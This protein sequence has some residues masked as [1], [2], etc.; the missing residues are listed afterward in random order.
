VDEGVS[1]AEDT[2]IGAMVGL[3]WPRGPFA[4][5]NRIGIGQAV[6]AAADV[7]RRHDLPLPSLLAGRAEPFALQAVSL[8]V[9]DGLAR[10]TMNRPNAMN[11]LDPET[12]ASLARAFDAAAADPAATAI[13]LEG[14]GKAFVAG[15]DIKFFIRGIDD[16]DIPRIVDFTRV[17]QELFLRIDRCPKPV[18]ARLNGLALGGGAELALA[19][20][21]IVAEP[22]ASIGFPETGIGIYPGLGGTQRLVGRT[23][24]AVARSLVL[25]GDVLP[26]A[27][28]AD[29]GLVDRVAPSGASMDAVR[30]LLADGA[31]EAGEGAGG[32]A[33]PGAAKAA[34][35]ALYTDGN[36]AA[37]LDGTFQPTD[38]AAGKAYKK[39]RAKAPVALKMADELMRKAPSTPI[40]EGVELELGGLPRI[41]STKDARAGL[42]SVI[43]RTRPTY[44]GR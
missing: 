2:D 3:R 8:I 40:A 21:A 15:A 10:I 18:V 20:D 5:A 13:V 25:T 4:L 14:R 11:A 44:E 28:A 22:G 7:A 36:V 12:V 38:D 39:L 31:V 1:S 17:G 30:Q 42:G 34:V 32:L 16:G 33:R 27:R 9:E 24:L 19:C 6:E 26:A 41:F 37:M 43:D 29:L 23:G 35:E